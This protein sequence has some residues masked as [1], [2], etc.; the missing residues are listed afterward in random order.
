MKVFGDRQLHRAATVCGGTFELEK[1]RL[2]RLHVIH[3]RD[4]VD[5]WALLALRRRVSKDLRHVVSLAIV[6]CLPDN[7]TC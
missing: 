6:V 7:Q 5:A 2:A 1:L 4:V 3:R